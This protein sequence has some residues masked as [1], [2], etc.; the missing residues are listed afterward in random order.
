M[1]LAVQLHDNRYR[2]ALLELLLEV[3]GDEY[4]ARIAQNGRAVILPVPK[5]RF[6]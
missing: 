3:R 4:A 1:A 6:G 5:G 2:G